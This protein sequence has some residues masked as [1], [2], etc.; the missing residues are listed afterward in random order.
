ML[1]AMLVLPL[2]A[3]VFLAW[4]AYTV[5][6]ADQPGLDLAELLDHIRRQR[7]FDRSEGDRAP[8]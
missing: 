3:C 8:V 5:D 1:A 7:L 6:P 2:F 4:S